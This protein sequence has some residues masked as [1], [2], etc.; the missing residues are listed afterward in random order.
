M[1]DEEL[2]PGSLWRQ[3][4]GFPF[5]STPVLVKL[6]KTGWILP[7][8]I[9][10]CTNR[11]NG[12]M[13]TSGPIEWEGSKKIKFYFSELSQP[14]TASM[15]GC[16]LSIKVSENKRTKFLGFGSALE[17]VKTIKASL[18]REGGTLKKDIQDGLNFTKKKSKLR[19]KKTNSRNNGDHINW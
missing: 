1:R 6:G 17:S 2:G 3:G 5:F 11:A 18:Y 12:F 8:E 7:E 19:R 14:P 9:C 15:T 16:I 10:R 13:E 4:Q